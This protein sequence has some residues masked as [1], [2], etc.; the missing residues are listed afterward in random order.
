MDITALRTAL[1][2]IHA[3]VGDDPV[4]AS[5]LCRIAIRAAIRAGVPYEELTTVNRHG[6]VLH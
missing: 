6:N 3:A 1:A 4:I 2:H 5:L